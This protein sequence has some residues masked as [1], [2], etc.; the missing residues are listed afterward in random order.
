MTPEELRAHLLTL[1]AKGLVEI[2]G[3]EDGQP[4]WDLTPAGRE[5]A[6]EEKEKADA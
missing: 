4:I 3:E 6:L 1:A 2:T 5:Q